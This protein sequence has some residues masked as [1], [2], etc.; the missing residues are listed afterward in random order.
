[1]PGVFPVIGR[2]EEES[3]ENRLLLE[4]LIPEEARISLFL[5]C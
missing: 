4:Q 5:A 3:E 1:M 2:T